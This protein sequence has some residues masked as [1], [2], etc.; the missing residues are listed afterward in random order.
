MAEDS[1]ASGRAATVARATANVYETPG[2]EAYVIE[3]PLPGL[4]RQEIVVEVDVGTI[5]VRTE[6]AR[7][8]EEEGRTYLVREHLVEPMA[9]VFEFPADIDTDNVRV[10]LEQGMLR[11]RAP[12]AAAGRPRVVKIAPEQ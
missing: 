5:T 8:E 10:I 9:R 1:N 4:T 12:K 3:V 6:P 7:T 2:G 11:I